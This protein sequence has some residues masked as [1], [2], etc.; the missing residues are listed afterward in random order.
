MFKK[1]LR[2]PDPASVG[3]GGL[4]FVSAV[5][6]WTLA[7]PNPLA[8]NGLPPLGWV[9]LL[10]VFLLC[11]RSK[12]SWAPFIGFLFGFFSYF[13]S[14]FWLLTFH[15]IAMWAVGL[16]Q[17]L[18][19]ALVFTLIRWIFYANRPFS[20]LAI[21]W[22][23]VAYEYIKTLGFL[24][25]PFGI[26]AYSQAAATVVKQ[27]A[28]VG[29]VGLVSWLMVVPQAAAA[30]AA[31]AFFG[32]PHPPVSFAGFAAALAAR[33]KRPARPKP[34]G[35]KRRRLPLPVQT[36]FRIAALL[37][38]AVVLTLS[39]SLGWAARP[40]SASFRVAA[41]ETLPFSEMPPAAGAG[42][43]A[44]EGKRPPSAEAKAAAGTAKK[45]P[46]SAVP[47][48]GEPV[49]PS[50]SGKQNPPP[51]AAP[52]FPTEAPAGDAVRFS[53]IQTNAGI[54]EAAVAAGKRNIRDLAYRKKSHY[55]DDLTRNIRLT[56]AALAHQ[57]DCV[58]WS[59]TSFIP[60]VDWYRQGGVGEGLGA[61]NRLLWFNRAM[62]CPLITGNSNGQPK[63]PNVWRT[64]D[65]RVDYNSALLLE[66]GHIRQ[67]YSKQKLVPF[68]ENY[69][70]GSR[71]PRLRSFL[72]DSLQ[73]SF[74]EKGKS[75]E[76][77]RIRS[78][79]CAVPIC[80]EDAFPALIRSMCRQ[81]ADCFIN[82]S[83]DSWSGSLSAQQQHLACSVFRAIET[84]RPFLRSTQ[85]GQTAVIE[86]NGTVTA[87]LP[88]FA[89]GALTVDLLPQDPSV[90]L[91]QKIGDIFPQTA[92][93]LSLLWFMLLLGQA[94]YAKKG[95][96]RKSS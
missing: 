57:P 20:S 94:V 17:G 24:G 16:A 32:R 96:T 87:Q 39:L 60:G 6:A 9:A 40:A 43:G 47:P 18:Y 53:L 3:K 7:F 52:A 79:R 12:A 8:K 37:T 2:R 23:W 83:N 11:F 42:A 76:L 36:G 91:Y 54:N 80:Y 5:L 72:S 29:G 41:A 85:S 69:P 68:T 93:T 88:P 56:I 90:P 27:A 4:L 38:Y 82:L 64:P 46:A 34:Q 78:L 33:R 73:C 21:G 66:K 81:G 61:V 55:Q 50:A 62:P 1:R 67:V 65:N 15:P 84:G 45:I 19:L 77:F 31:A 44:P 30:E 71:F 89:P 75:N 13:F 74:W 63:D 70:F 14:Q 22:V 48:A 86:A 92:C 51:E 28:S 25:Y 26:L 59:E 58:V 49:L 10:P 35:S 95:K